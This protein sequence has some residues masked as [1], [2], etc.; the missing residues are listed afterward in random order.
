MVVVAGSLP[1]RGHALLSSQLASGRPR[2]CLRRCLRHW[3]CCLTVGMDAVLA[4]LWLLLRHFLLSLLLFCSRHGRGCCGVVSVVI[5]GVVALSRSPWT[6]L[7]LL[8]CRY[9]RRHH[10]LHRF[11][12]AI[13]ASPSSTRC[14]RG[15]WG[16]CCWVVALSWLSSA[17]VAMLGSSW[18]PLLRGRCG[19]FIVAV[20][21]LQSS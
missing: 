5:V 4:G 7:L 9:D 13:V 6:W 1:C 12:V 11:V 21:A 17:V 16:C 18:M 2:H 10:R 8:G 3:C 20:V 14:R 19:I 15:R